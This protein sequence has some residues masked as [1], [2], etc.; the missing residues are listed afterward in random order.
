MKTRTGFI[1]NSS[2]TSFV[3]IANETKEDIYNKLNSIR[4]KELK[5]TGCSGDGG[6]FIIETIEDYHRTKDKKRLAVYLAD[7]LSDYK[8]N[9]T[10]EES[11]VLEFS[12][13]E[14]E[15]LIEQNLLYISIDWSFKKTIKRIKDSYSPLKQIS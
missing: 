11:E 7:F 14:A 15:K 8:Y 3:I 2:S 9:A 6:S 10:L 4:E 1:S 13:E 12:V 5:S